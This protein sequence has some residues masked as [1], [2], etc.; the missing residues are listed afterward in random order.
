M[1]I[2]VLGLVEEEDF[3]LPGD[4]GSL[5]FDRFG[6]VVGVLF[7]GSG[8]FGG[9]TKT[10]LMPMESLLE[11]I[12]WSAY[13]SRAE[14]DWFDTEEQKAKREEEE[15]R[16]AEWSRLQAEDRAKWPFPEW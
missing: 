2:S 7:S 12:K 14:M 1:Q 5:V 11:D 4:S 3:G 6:E 8:Q 10:Y 9:R 13:A 15:Q 16:E